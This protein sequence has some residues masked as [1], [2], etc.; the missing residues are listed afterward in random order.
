VW[1]KYVW[2]RNTENFDSIQ[3]KHH[4]ACFKSPKGTGS[5]CFWL[6]VYFI[7]QSYLRPRLS[8]YN[9]FHLVPYS[10]WKSLKLIKT[11]SKSYGTWMKYFCWIF[12]SKDSH[13]GLTFLWGHTK[14]R[15]VN[16]PAKLASAV[17]L[18]PLKSVFAIIDL[19]KIIF[20][21]LALCKKFCSGRE[22]SGYII[23]WIWLICSD[24]LIPC[25]MSQFTLLLVLSL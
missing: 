17:P 24:L 18:T 3:L 2:C 13:S 6:L 5:R 20:A 4:L 8:G 14:I 9:Y 10:P 21:A 12:P 23:W 19:A 11:C 25:F 15:G 1:T 16:E 7:N 22:G